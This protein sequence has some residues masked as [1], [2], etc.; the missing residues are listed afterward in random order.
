ML[1][2][3]VNDPDSSVREKVAEDID[4]FLPDPA[5]EAALHT[6]ANSDTNAGVRS[7]ALKTLSD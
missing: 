4:S 3:L 1:S 2:S 7:H 5:I 6:A